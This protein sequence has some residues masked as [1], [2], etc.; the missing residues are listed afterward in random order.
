[1]RTSFES[2]RNVARV[3]PEYH[4]NTVLLVSDPLHSAR[5]RE[6]ALYLGFRAAYT[7]P[8]SYLELGW[9]SGSKLDDLVKET[10]ALT[11]YNLGFDRG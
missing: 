4:I 2:L 9:S 10:V 8:A 1:G 7:S 11:L 6:M 5:I 3:A